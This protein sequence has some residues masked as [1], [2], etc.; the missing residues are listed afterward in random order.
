VRVKGVLGKAPPPGTVEEDSLAEAEQV[1]VPTGTTSPTSV[2]TSV[3][4][5]IYENLWTPLSPML[6]K[7]FYW[8]ISGWKSANSNLTALQLFAGMFSHVEARLDS[9]RNSLATESL[10]IFSPHSPGYSFVCGRVAIHS[11]PVTSRQNVF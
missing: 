6:G 4:I 9:I 11:M 10:T 5:Y 8:H 3:L 2:W 7:V 1:S